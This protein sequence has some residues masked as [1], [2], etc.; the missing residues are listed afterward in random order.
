MV[1]AR[2]RLDAE[3]SGD[4]GGGELRDQLLG[5]VL[6]ISEGSDHVPGQ[7][8]GVPGPVS[9]LVGDGRVVVLGAVEPG[10]VGHVDLVGTRAVVG[11]VASVSDDHAAAVDPRGNELLRVVDRVGSLDLVRLRGLPPFDL[12]GVEHGNTPPAHPAGFSFLTGLGVLLGALVL[13]RYRYR[14][15]GA[16]TLDDGA[17]GGLPLVER[18]P[19]AGPEA[20]HHR[21]EGEAPPVA[22]AVRVPGLDVGG[23]EDVPA[24]VLPRHPP[25]VGLGSGLDCVDEPGRHLLD[26]L[27]GPGLLRRCGRGAHVGAPWALAL[28][29]QAPPCPRC[30][31]ERRSPGERRRAQRAG[32]P[33]SPNPKGRSDHR[34]RR[35]CRTSERAAASENAGG[36]FCGG[37][38]CAAS[39]GRRSD[40]SDGGAAGADGAPHGATDAASVQ[41]ACC[42]LA[43]GSGARLPPLPFRC[44]ARPGSRPLVSGLRGDRRHPSTSTCLRPSAG[45]GLDGAREPVPL[46]D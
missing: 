33:R 35:S 46:T 1:V 26:E 16:F 23:L 8:A 12:G 20:V 36:W 38:G 25:A 40:Q 7:P 30:D 41:R 31:A 15:E 22:A 17:P 34:E 18:S 39:E 45:R 21:G 32:T 5:R 43:R 29:G 4:G 11:A 10:D 13:D 3:V 44:R 28:R 9:G 37:V 14:R 2:G 6:V 42:A 27:I 24:G 19:G